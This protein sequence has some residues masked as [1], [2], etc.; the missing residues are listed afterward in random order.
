MGN[1]GSRD[2]DG[3]ALAGDRAATAA[4]AA[5]LAAAVTRDARDE[6]GLAEDEFAG[7]V[8]AGGA[9]EGAGDAEEA[10]AGPRFPGEDKPSRIP[11]STESEAAR[12]RSP[13][14]VAI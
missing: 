13:V 7:A 4:A 6:P 10:A 14:G 12:L 3:I 8:W 1:G 2:D 11:S 9:G 5:A